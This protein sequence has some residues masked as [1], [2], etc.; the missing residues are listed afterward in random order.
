MISFAL[1]W[2]Y[3]TKIKADAKSKIDPSAFLI[4]GFLDVVLVKVVLDGIAKII[5]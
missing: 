3:V 5:A 2:V 4:T 1:A